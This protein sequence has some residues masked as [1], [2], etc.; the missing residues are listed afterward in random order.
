MNGIFA[1][2]LLAASTAFG[3]LA[4]AGAAQAQDTAEDSDGGPIIVTAQKREQTLAEI[5][6]SVTVLG[7]ET[8]E[9]QGASDF[10]DYIGLIPGLSIE[11]T[12]P[13][14]SRISLRGIN[15]GG[16]ASTVGVY[17]D[18][19]PFGSS[20]GLANGAILSGDFDT[21]D[22]DRI[23]VLRGPQGTLYGASSLGGVLRFITNPPSTTALA[24]RG[25]VTVE[26]VSSGDIGYSGS[27][28][29]NV[30][31]SETFAIRASAFY[32]QEAGYIDSIG[33]AGSDVEDDI[34]DFRTFGGRISAL[35]RPSSAVTIRLS[36]LAQNIE[37]DASSYVEADTDNLQ[38]LYGGLTQSQF[39][40]E[41]NDVKYRLYNASVD[42]DLGF[43]TLFSST[44]LGNF[45]QDL[46][47]DFSFSFGPLITSIF[48]DPVTRPL[49]LYLDQTTQTEKFT[50]EVRLVSAESDRFEW[51]VGL[52]YT[53]EDSRIDQ[54][55]VAVEAVSEAIATGL[56]LLGDVFL[57]SRLEEIAAFANGTIHLTDRF[58][59][60]LGGRLSRNEQVA[61]QSLDGVLAGGSAAFDDTVSEETV[62]T[63]SVAPRFE[64][65]D[66]IALYARV[67]SGYRP[68]GPNVLPPNVPAGTPTS[69]SAD[70]LVSYEAGFRASFPRQRMSVDFAI[71]YLDWKDIQLF[72]LVNGI[73]INAN[74]GTARSLGGELSVTVRP[75]RGLS[76]AVN[77]AYVDATLSQ[78]T[79]PVV[80]GF[81]GDRLPYSPQWSGNLS[82]DYD[83][84]ISRAAAAFVGGNLRLVGEQNADFDFAYR[85]QFGSQR[86]VDGYAVV[87]LRAGIQGPERRWSVE[88]FIRNLT[89]A[90]GR[91]SVFGVAGDLPNDAVG[92][93]LIRPRT[94][95]VTLTAGF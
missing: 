88:A 70:R 93:G 83:W 50:Q 77:A 84:S 76:L 59:V 57:D 91:T 79:D 27:G 21:F 2:R 92:T 48:G 43:A 20:S 3:A 95:G 9:R 16:V 66:A 68:G 18:D 94:I 60:S 56:P 7:E 6:Q 22:V 61:S 58:E 49:G 81:D 67:A 23:E 35:F 71:Y 69:Y 51:L 25:R 1:R 46:L 26:S 14:V 62:F 30:P 33:T 12:T 19:T 90:R 80:G 72:A 45:R 55:F 5:P 4:F 44:S 10:Q 75:V 87:D 31:L 78:D 24:G 29:V 86:E 74:G 8:L 37:A 53:R 85:T 15:T 54:D 63:Y 65:S 40:P 39:I 64:I 32:R 41:F 52:Y 13:G 73:G 47:S 42:I 36:A 38:I 89:N 11:A 34:N 17:V 28:W 82:V